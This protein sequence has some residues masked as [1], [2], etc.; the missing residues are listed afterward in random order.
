MIL[1]FTA[2][3]DGGFNKIM[4]LNSLLKAG[5]KSERINFRCLKFKATSQR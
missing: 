3:N 2:Q 4:E 5:N 1:T